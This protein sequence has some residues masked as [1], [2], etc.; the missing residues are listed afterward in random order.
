[1]P[2]R[3]LQLHVTASDKEWLFAYAKARSTTP[4]RVLHELL[5]AVRDGKLHAQTKPFLSERLSFR[6]DT[7][8]Y[9][10]FESK[11]LDWETTCRELIRG[12]REGCI[13]EDIS[14]S[15]NPFPSDKVIP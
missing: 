10:H 6:L 12:L 1:M 7:S 15:P 13:P 5:Y 14:L 11:D 4:T 2:T 3:P 8:L 9:D